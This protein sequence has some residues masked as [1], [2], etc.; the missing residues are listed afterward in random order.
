MKTTYQFECYWS[1][2]D[3]WHFSFGTKKLWQSK[4]VYIVADLIMDNICA[5]Y[6]NQEKFTELQ[7]AIDY[8][9]TGKRE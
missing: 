2:N 5:K 4:G 6:Q 9:R 1:Q 8:M 7:E 3:G